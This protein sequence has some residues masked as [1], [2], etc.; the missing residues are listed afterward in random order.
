MP[1]NYRLCMPKLR[2]LLL[3]NLTI[4]FHIFW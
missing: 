4:C 2:P 3:I 1:K